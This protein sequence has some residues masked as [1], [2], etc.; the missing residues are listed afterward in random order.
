MD[1]VTATP[2]L[3]VKA[4]AGAIV[5]VYVALAVWGW[6]TITRHHAPRIGVA[7]YGVGLGVLLIMLAAAFVSYAADG[8]GVRRR[9]LL[10]TVAL[11]W[12]EIARCRVSRRLGVLRCVLC[13]RAGSRRL[14]INFTMLEENGQDL[15]DLLRVR[16]AEVAPSEAEG[17]TA[18]PRERDAGPRAA[19][20]RGRAY[21]ALASAALLGV[22]LYLGATQGSS[23][24]R[25]REL[26][27]HGQTAVG[28]VWA[29]LE[30]EGDRGALYRFTTAE[31]GDGS[32]ALWIARKD[33]GRYVD[34]NRIQVRY[35]SR[36]PVVNLPE[37]VLRERWRKDTRVIGACALCLA[38]AFAVLLGLGLTRRPRG[39]AKPGSP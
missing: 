36:D 8:E 28:T 35:L 14:T 38:T 31:G 30:D 33:Y 4:I 34:G 24:W 11:P 32:G 12:E 37:R 5:A 27:T 20:E 6:I 2:P 3:R 1:R 25:D 23:I 22:A 17:L 9:G 39:H 29:M 18:L 21:A 15:L 10:G 19:R 16:L 13:D 26:L 7:V